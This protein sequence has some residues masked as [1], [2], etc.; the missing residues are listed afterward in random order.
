MIT[1]N[2]KKMIELKNANQWVTILHIKDLEYIVNDLQPCCEYI[3]RIRSKNEIGYSIYKCHL[4]IVTTPPG[5]PDKMKSPYYTDKTDTT[6]V[7]E[8]EMPNDNGS[9]ISYYDLRYCSE[10]ENYDWHY[11]DHIIGNSIYITNLVPET[12]FTFQI[13]ANNK[14]GYGEWS[15]AKYS[16]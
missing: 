5:R 12:E 7:L 6:I 3:F 2:G 9:P 10:F 15:E 14:M 8:W 13:R 16:I 4:D 1:K 11:E